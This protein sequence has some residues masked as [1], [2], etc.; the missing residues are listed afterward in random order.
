MPVKGALRTITQTVLSWPGVSKHPHRFGATEYRLG[1]WREI[2]HVHGDDV[3]DIPFPVKVR[4]ELIAE[5]RA[6]R[7]HFV[8]DIGAVSLF[9]REAA[10]LQRAI[11]LLSL[12]YDRALRQKNHRKAQ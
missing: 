8:P 12:S 11:D 1:E 9:L 7:H 6:E 3:V 10:D 4:D 2:G 5:G